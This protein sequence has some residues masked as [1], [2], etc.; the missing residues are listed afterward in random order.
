M[1]KPVVAAIDMGYGHLRPAAALADHLATEVV[2]MDAPPFGTR[3]DRA[4]WTGIRKFYEP[5][6]RMSQ[7]GAAAG[8]MR[9]LLNT[10]TAIPPPLPER[11]LSGPTQGTRWMSSAARAGVGRALA[12]YLRESG[13]PLLAT[14][15]AAAVLAE[16]HG[17]ERLHCVIT[18]T[19][20]NRVWAPPDSKRTGI[21]YFA[22]TDSARRRMESYGVPRSRIRVTGYPLPGELV[23]RDRAALK[24][25][26]RARMERIGKKGSAPLIVFAVGGAGV[27]VPLAKTLLSGMEKQIREGRLRLA[28]VAG[29]RKEVASTLSATLAGLGLAGHAGTELLYDPD[30]FSYIRR[31]NALLARAD[32]LWSKPSEL[33]FFAGLGLPFIAAPPVGAHEE[34]NLRWATDRGAALLQHDPETAGQWLLEWVEDGVLASA[35]EAG[36]CLPQTGVYDIADQVDGA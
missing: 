7:V 32:A 30:V 13:A 31:F 6:T 33:T 26:F 4:F 36:M 9:A 1:V 34:R 18:D 16:M 10:L 11:D 5:L 21:V 17:A 23:G 24:R 19:D 8:P 15:Y 3:R 35:A 28:L 12:R 2:Q 22:P 29:I 27:H 20:V 25:N 14:F